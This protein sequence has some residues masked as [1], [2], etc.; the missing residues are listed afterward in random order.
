M[1]FDELTEENF[2]LY[3]AKVYDNPQCHS[4][5]EFYADLDRIKYLKKLFTRYHTKQDLRER[6]ILNHI[7]LLTNV[8]G[9]YHSTKI[10]FFQIDKEHWVYMKPFFVLLGIMPREVKKDGEVFQD[11]EIGLDEGIIE[12]LRKL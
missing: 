4:I 1:L 6:L 8:F 3:C 12:A 7:I 5:D 9:P 11:D 10:L 2:I